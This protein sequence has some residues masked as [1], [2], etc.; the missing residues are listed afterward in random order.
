MVLFA[1]ITGSTVWLF[2]VI[3]MMWSEKFPASFALF[4]HFDLQ[5]NFDTG[6]RLPTGVLTYNRVGTLLAQEFYHC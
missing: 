4:D 6:D 1:F 3:R 2:T 5:L